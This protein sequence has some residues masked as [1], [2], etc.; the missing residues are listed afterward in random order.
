[1]SLHKF[2]NVDKDMLLL[3]LLIDTE[4]FDVSPKC[5][6]FKAMGQTKTCN[7]LS[8][9]FYISVKGRWK[10]GKVKKLSN[11]EMAIRCMTRDKEIRFSICD[12]FVDTYGPIHIR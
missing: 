11:I 4:S 6:T 9:R 7:Y 5:L 1:M 2:T 8:L 12:N 10:S 3:A